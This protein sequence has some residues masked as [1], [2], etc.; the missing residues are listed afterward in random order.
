MKFVIVIV[1]ALL[2]LGL[3]VSYE[4]AL[5]YCGVD[6]LSFCVL[7][8]MIIKLPSWIGSFCGV[9]VSA[10]LAYRYAMRKQKFDDTNKNYHQQVDAANKT[11][12][13]LTMCF[14]HLAT[15]KSTYQNKVAGKENITRS[16]KIQHVVGLRYHYVDFDPTTLYFLMGVGEVDPVSPKNSNYIF[17]VFQRYNHALGL[18]ERR[19]AMA[20]EFSEILVADDLDNTNG[21]TVSLEL[22]FIK[23]KV[24]INKF[25]NYLVITEH[26]I[27]LIDN[28]IEEIS[29][30]MYEL[31]IVCNQYFSDIASNNPGFSYKIASFDPSIESNADIFQ[32]VNKL[33]IDSQL[34]RLIKIWRASEKL[35]DAHDW[36]QQQY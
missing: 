16:L 31:A 28:S 26:Q 27:N 24:G 8:D 33:D 17:N 10:T 15:I 4:P 13:M 21:R 1:V 12:M 25:I 34:A 23:N 22:G 18:A 29:N 11:I 35:Q 2:L 6:H 19:N 14:N 36:R 7:S 9:F 5:I 30:L 3:F 32:P 20:N